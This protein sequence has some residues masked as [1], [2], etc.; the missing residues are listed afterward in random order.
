MHPRTK[1]CTHL[2]SF[3]RHHGRPAPHS[4]R[5][6]P[7]NSVNREL[8]GA[9]TCVFMAVPGWEA[10]DWSFVSFFYFKI[11]CG[12]SDFL[13]LKKAFLKK[14]LLLLSTSP[15]AFPFCPAGPGTCRA[16]SVRSSPVSFRAGGGSTSSSQPSPRGWACAFW[17]HKRSHGLLL[18]VLVPSTLPLKAILIYPHQ[19]MMEM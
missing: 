1:F 2:S 6:S 5:G 13:Q 15:P 8:A 11:S 19:K 7:T 17:V 18:N 4:R 16:E 10:A 14:V 9:H 12:F 3:N